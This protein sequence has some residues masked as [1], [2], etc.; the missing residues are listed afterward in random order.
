MVGE[1]YYTLPE[2]IMGVRAASELNNKQKSGHLN[3]VWQFIGLREP[4]FSFSFK[5]VREKEEEKRGSTPAHAKG[6][7]EE[8]LDWRRPTSLF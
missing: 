2:N 4:W 7:E 8:S 6:K 5:K 1:A 3:R